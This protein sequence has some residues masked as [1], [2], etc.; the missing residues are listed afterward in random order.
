MHHGVTELSPRRAG[1]TW[2]SAET[3]D[4][5]AEIRGILLALEDALRSGAADTD[6]LRTRVE[7]PLGSLLL[8]PAVGESFL[9]AK[10]ITVADEARSDRPLIQGLYVLFGAQTLEPLAVL[11]GP[12]LTGVRTAGVS[13]LAASHLA[14]APFRRLVVFGIGVQAAAHIKAM[15]QLFALETIDVVG[16]DPARTDRFITTLQDPEGPQIRRASADAVGDADLICCCTNSAVPLFDGAAVR[17][18]ALVIAVGSHE[19][20]KRELDSTL[21]V[22]SM[23]VVESVTTALAEAGEVVIPMSEGAFNPSAIVA[24]AD[25]VRGDSDAGSRPVVFKSTGMS[26][27]DLAVAQRIYLAATDR[28]NAAEDAPI[29]LKGSSTR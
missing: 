4:S 1:P 18:R 14:A 7:G 5:H 2:L 19:P 27:Q 8:M 3:V 12:A 15:S 23:V 10:L 13:A 25:V 22:R 17:E 20:K 11:D 24:L 16:R 21:M 28:P 9:G 26:W 6:V 29:P